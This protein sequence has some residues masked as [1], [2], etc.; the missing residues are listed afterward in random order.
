MKSVDFFFSTLE[1]LCILLWLL[2]L[3]FHGISECV[4]MC[5]SVSVY[6][7]CV[8]FFFFFSCL[9]VFPFY[10]LFYYYSLDVCLFSKERNQESESIGREGRWQGA[11]KS[12]GKKNYS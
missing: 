6:I 2:V 3:F 7:S 9:V 4:N 10:I 8:L 11:Q 12:W 5:A 1:I